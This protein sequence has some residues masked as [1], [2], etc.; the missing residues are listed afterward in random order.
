MLTLNRTNTLLLLICISCQSI[1]AQPAGYKP[2]TDQ[3]LFKQKLNEASKSANTIQCD[4]IQEKYLTVLSDKIVSSG[5]FYFKKENQLRW[6]YTSP[7]K[8][9][10]ILSNNKVL[11]K[12]DNKTNQYDLGSNKTFKEINNIMSG[13]VQGNLLNDDTK[14]KSVFFENAKNYLVILTPVDKTMKGYIKSIHLY[15]DRKSLSVTMIKLVE[16]SDDYTL[17]QFNNR[18]QNIIL[19]AELFKI[20]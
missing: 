15:F 20:K 1:F 10:I 6:E 11:I 13:A 4:F 3:A 9:L 5:K 19:S 12:D 16:N 8:Y 2:I 7:I 17:I 18:K 14:Y